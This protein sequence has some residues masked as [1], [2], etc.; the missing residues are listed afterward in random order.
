MKTAVKLGAAVLAM[1]LATSSASADVFEFSFTTA[2]DSAHGWLTT[3]VSEVVTAISGSID[4]FAITGLSGYGG[5]DQQLF[6]WVYPYVDYSGISF[7]ANNV[8]YNWSSYPVPKGA[9]ANSVSDPGGTGVALALFSG[10]TVTVVPEVSSWAMML[11][12]FASLG[13]VGYRR[14]K[15]W[16]FVG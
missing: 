6:S 12:G 11:A 15:A 10:V 14:K 4:G 7:V 9:L 13:F 1:A 2:G 5:A 16:A 8:S 3:D